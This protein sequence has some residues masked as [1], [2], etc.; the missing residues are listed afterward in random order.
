[1]A[2]GTERQ[3]IFQDDADRE[4]F[5][6]R[7][8]G[9]VDAAALTV[10]AWA[11]LPNH[12]HLLVRTGRQPLARSMR[13]L[14]T[15][16]AGA[17][18]RRYRRKGHLFQSRYKSVVCDEETYFLELV[19]YLHLNPLRARLVTDLAGLAEYAYS[20]HGA[21]VGRQAYAWQDTAAVLQQFGTTPR[22]ARREYL[23]FVA[24]GMGQGR[25]TEL[26]GG[27]L[28]RSAGG[29]A[30]IQELRRGREGY[31]GDERILGSSEFVERI[32]QEVEEQAAQAQRPPRSPSVETV[33][34][35]VCEAEGIRI[36]EIAGTGRRAVVS[37]ARAGVAYLW[38]ERL[39]Q[40]GP[41]AARALGLHP[42]T[43]Y[44]VA[45][46]GRQ[47]AVYWEGVLGKK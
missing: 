46:R 41:V 7:V 20:G 44:A 12:F 38:L 11:L 34:E 15:G 43:I 10:Y 19:R 39:G 8:A 37:R 26:Q 5:V 35:R 1:M 36:E 29:W 32:R 16:Y 21:L 31:L 40:R 18:N 25:R 17:F 28:I 4:N 42:A 9:L 6:Q 23:R 45:R 3:R 30:A 14:L 22:W 13:S 2:R 27:G 33:I 47:D 24:E